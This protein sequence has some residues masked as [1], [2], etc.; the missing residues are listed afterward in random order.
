[1][2]TAGNDATPC[3]KSTFYSVANIWKKCLKFRRKSDHAMCLECSR[4]KSAI[5]RANDLHLKFICWGVVT[6]CVF[7]GV[8]L[9]VFPLISSI[10]LIWSVRTS[11]LMQVCAM[12]CY[13]TTRS[14][15]RTEV[16]TG[17]RDQDL[18]RPGTCYVASLTLTTKQSCCCLFFLTGEFLKEACMSFAN[19][20][21]LHSGV[22]WNLPE[23]DFIEISLAIS[24]IS[25]T[26]TCCM[27]HGHGCYLY[28]TDEGMGC[29]S[30]WQWECVSGHCLS[31]ICFNMFLIC[32]RGC[33]GVIW[34]LQTKVMRSLQKV[35]LR[36]RARNE[37]W[38]M[39]SL[40]RFFWGVCWFSSLFFQ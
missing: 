33:F 11:V 12:S 16:L 38:P 19:A 2:R 10:L 1:M 22:G 27:M 35:F 4:L 30:N 6:F 24:G 8:G 13:C 21:F 28:I 3:S 39:E 7:L 32:F 40:A 23:A 18:S 9:L 34:V 20:T 31:F 26:L 14:S 36:T 15:G 37:Q 29:G 5:N 25:L 17:R